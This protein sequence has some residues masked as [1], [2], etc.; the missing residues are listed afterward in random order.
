MR[1]AA[2]INHPPHQRMQP[3]ISWI[4]LGPTMKTK[5][6]AASVRMLMTKST[7]GMRSSGLVP[8]AI[9]RVVR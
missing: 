8:S 4:A 1:L 2:S 9:P 7:A 3:P 5:T 6:D